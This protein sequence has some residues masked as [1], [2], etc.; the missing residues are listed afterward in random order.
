MKISSSYNLSNS[1]EILRILKEDPKVASVA[2]RD[3][4]SGSKPK[5]D[6]LSG[7][8]GQITEK[9]SLSDHAK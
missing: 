7:A 9:V 1:Q 3:S 8:D 4:V 5:S 6:S 2:T